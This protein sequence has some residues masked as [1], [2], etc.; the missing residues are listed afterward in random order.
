MS[1][2]QVPKKNIPCENMLVRRHKK[3][4]SWWKHTCHLQFPKTIFLSNYWVLCSTNMLRSLEKPFDWFSFLDEYS[5]L[6]SQ[7]FNA[8]PNFCLLREDPA[9]TQQNEMYKRLTKM[10]RRQTC[11]TTSCI[12]IFTSW[13]C[14]VVYFHS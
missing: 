6:P 3:E 1:I 11:V 9:R 4:K 2:Y 5:I 8:N 10:T 14:T 12:D 7:C 13:S